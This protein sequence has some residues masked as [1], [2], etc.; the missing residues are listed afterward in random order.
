MNREG[1]EVAVVSVFA[2]GEKGGGANSSN[3]SCGSVTFW[4]RIRIRGSIE[5]RIRTLPGPG[6]CPQKIIFFGLHF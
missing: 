5:L 1:K 2:D 6:R 4:V 3:Q